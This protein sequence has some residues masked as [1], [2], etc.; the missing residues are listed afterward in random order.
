MILFVLT[1]FATMPAFTV[2]TVRDILDPLQFSGIIRDLGELLLSGRLDSDT[3]TQKLGGRLST[4]GENS[5]TVTGTG[6]EA[7]L[8]KG[9]G[10]DYDFS[11]FFDSSFGLKLSHLMQVLGNWE[12][13]HESKS[14]SVKFTLSAPD[15]RCV[16]EIFA[17]MP[18]AVI[19][20]ASR[21]TSVTIRQRAS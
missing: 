2:A 12:T 13:I 17:R 8:E 21:V 18:S 4:T 19:I 9:N 14:S 5:W 6:Y 10:K 3:L 20:P 11:I 16:A 7:V 1:V 15:R